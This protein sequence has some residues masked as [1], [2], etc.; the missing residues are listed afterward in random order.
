M[1]YL[2][3]GWAATGLSG[4]QVHCAN[5]ELA[6]F[7]PPSGQT[8]GQYLAR[9]LQGGAPGQLYNPSATRQCQYCPL[10]DADQFLAGRN[11]YY[12]Q[13]WRNFGIGWAFICFNVG[14]HPC[15]TYFSLVT[16]SSPC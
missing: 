7:N 13:R 16:P 11:I 15:P 6:T 3:S 10:T 14:V 5:N 8:C 4:R 9:Y 1:T 2:V 12:S